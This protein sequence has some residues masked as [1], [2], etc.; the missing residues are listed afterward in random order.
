MQIGKETDRLRNSNRESLFQTIPQEL[1]LR[2]L[3]LHVGFRK[4]S[5]VSIW[6]VCVMWCGYCSLS[7]W[8][9]QSHSNMCFETTNSWQTPECFNVYQSRTC[10]M[11]L[12]F[13]TEHYPEDLV[14]VFNFK[15]NNRI[16]SRIILHAPCVPVFIV[17]T[18]CDMFLMRRNSLMFSI[19]FLQPQRD[20]VSVVGTFRRSVPLCRCRTNWVLEAWVLTRKNEFLACKVSRSASASAFRCVCGNSFTHGY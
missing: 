10:R 1:M 7:T 20:R 4:C 9:Y 11:Y 18:V 15:F 17:A 5:K 3:I 19:W 8:E 14:G 12:F 6:C 13:T 2:Y 16:L